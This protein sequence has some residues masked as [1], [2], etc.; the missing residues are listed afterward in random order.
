MEPHDPARHFPLEALPVPLVFATYR[1]IRDANTAFGAL[2]GYEVEELRGQSFSMLYPS[3]DDFVMVGDLWQ[4]NFSGGRSYTDERIM[5]RRDG[6]RFWCHVRGRSMVGADP[7]SEAIYCFDA[8]ARPAHH[9]RSGLTDRQRQIVTLVAQGKT[10]A[11]IAAE[12]SLSPRTVETHRYRLIRQL[13]FRN[14]AELV[15]WFTST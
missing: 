11:A 8:M 1:I 13:G 14:T 15:T 9:G 12:L 3:V 5:R 4:A 7:F 6:T 2:F 10:N